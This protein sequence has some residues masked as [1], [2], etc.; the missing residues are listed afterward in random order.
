MDFSETRLDAE[1]PMWGIM[2]AWISESHGAQLEAS[3]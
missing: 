1:L 2:R 3:C